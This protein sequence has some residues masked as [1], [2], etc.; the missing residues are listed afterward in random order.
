MARRVSLIMLTEIKGTDGNKA[1]CLEAPNNA[2][3]ILLKAQHA[4]E[5]SKLEENQFNL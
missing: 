2:S 3:L 1:I 4:Q 5:K